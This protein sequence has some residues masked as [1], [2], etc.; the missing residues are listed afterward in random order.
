MIVL[1]F[2]E[3]SEQPAVCVGCGKFIADLLCV[4]FPTVYNVKAEGYLCDRCAR[5]QS[6]SMFA[7]L[8]VLCAGAWHA[9][10]ELM[11][12]PEDAEDALEQLKMRCRELHLAH[13]AHVF[14]QPE[15]DYY[16]TSEATQ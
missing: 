7:L 3:A 16:L 1:K 9:Y 6:P 13:F 5:E 8:A 12:S 2:V 11:A 10:Q 15:P 4:S 14:G